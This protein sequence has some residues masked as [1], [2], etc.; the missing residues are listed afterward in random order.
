MYVTFAKVSNELVVMDLKRSDLHTIFTCQAANNN[1]SV[2]VSTSVKLD[3][4]CESSSLVFFVSRVRLM[5][6]STRI[7]CFDLSEVT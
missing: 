5:I 3:M 2:P 1:I 6:Y 7:S 4:Q